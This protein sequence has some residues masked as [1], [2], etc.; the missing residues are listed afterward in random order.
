[1]E[2]L[3]EK[4]KFQIRVDQK[5]KRA[6]VIDVITM[7]TK[8]NSDYCAKTFD[9]LGEDV[10]SECEKSKIN[11]KGKAIWVASAKV[12]VTIIW[13]LPGAA[14]KEFRMKCAEYICRILGGDESLVKEMELRA[15]RVSPEQKEIFLKD[16]EMPKLPEPTEEEQKFMIK[17]RK[18]ELKELEVKIADRWAAVKKQQI[19]NK[20][21]EIEFLQGLQNTALFQE[22]AHLAAAVKDAMMLSLRPASSGAG[23]MTTSSKSLK[24]GFEY[25]PDFTAL[26][27]DMGLRRLTIKELQALGRDVLASFKREFG[28]A[29]PETEKYVNGGYRKVKAYPMEHYEW[30]KKKVSEW[31]NLQS[32]HQIQ[33]IT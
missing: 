2:I 27:K 8:K 24:E 17:K 22:D 4:L 9:R 19:E 30:V 6:S 15:M 29:P 12:L 23:V 32:F 1:M 18:V 11:G 5:S 31:Y 26:I 28:T 16:V 10:K 33:C 7:V 13:I 25:C 3:N 20:K 21:L 14:A